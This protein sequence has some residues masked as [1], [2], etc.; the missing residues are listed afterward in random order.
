[1]T[2]SLKLSNLTARNLKKKHYQFSEICSNSLLIQYI[3]INKLD[4]LYRRFVAPLQTDQLSNYMDTVVRQK[5]GIIPSHV[6][7]GGS[8]RDSNGAINSLTFSTSERR[9]QLSIGRFY[10]TKL[11]YRR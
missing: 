5:L 3:F 11:R 2:F 9:V 1:M 10:D 4:R 7:F 6:K 8:S